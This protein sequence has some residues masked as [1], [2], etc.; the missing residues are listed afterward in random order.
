M[1]Y[2]YVQIVEEALEAANIGQS[3]EL[4]DWDESAVE[5]DGS[6][7]IKPDKDHEKTCKV[8]FLS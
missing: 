1:F 7:R 5:L 6:D 2:I 3:K 4:G 8:R